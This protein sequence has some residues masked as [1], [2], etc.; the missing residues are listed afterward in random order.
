VKR[1]RPVSLA[2][3]VVV[4]SALSTLSALAHAEPSDKAR[5]REAYDL[6]LEAHKRGDVHKAAEEFARADALAP[7]AVALQAALDAAIE[8]DD[9]PLG[10]ELIERSKREPAPPGLASSITVAHLKFSGR[11]GRL[12]VICPQ[13]STCTAKVDERPVEVDRIVWTNTGQHSVVVDVDGDTQTKR[14]EVSADRVLDVTGSKGAPPTVVTGASTDVA[15][16][17]P[18]A[19]RRDQLRDGL[20]PIVFYGGV[21]LTVALA[22]VTTFFALDASSTHGAFES[23]GCSR[24][25]FDACQRL[26]D[27]GESSQ[28]A[29]NVALALTAVSGIATTVVGAVFTNWKGPVVTAHPGGGGASWRL[30][31]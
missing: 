29:T 4:G 28:T 23:A 18:D 5:A 21:G 10:A 9:A 17:H 1:L 16:P 26:K 11:T 25:N 20:P 3:V 30:T 12:R 15:E 6:G 7:S 19:R 24:A 14:V 31:F 27:E 8:S 13:G 22:G 2:L